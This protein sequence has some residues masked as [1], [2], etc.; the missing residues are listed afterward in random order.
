LKEIQNRLEAVSNARLEQ[1]GGSSSSSSILSDDDELAFWSSLFDSHFLSFKA[2]EDDDM[3]FF[4]RDLGMISSTSKSSTSTSSTS[5]ALV[6]ALDAAPEDKL[7]VLR[8]DSPY[9][10]ALTDRCIDWE[11]SVCLNAV[12]H[13][14][15]YKLAVAIG[16]RQA[17]PT[18]STLSSIASTSTQLNLFNK[19]TKRVYASPSKR[20]MDSK[21]GQTQVTYPILCFAVDDFQDIYSNLIVRP[22]QMLC[23]QVHPR[24]APYCQCKHKHTNTHTHT[25]TT[26]V[27]KY[28]LQNRIINSIAFTTGCCWY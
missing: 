14:F 23:V 9:I 6:S 17:Q 5:T 25:H 24:Q 4:V 27:F 11:H 10:P 3:L 20:R 13:R 28:T 8:R 15:T 12:L 26:C 16:E 19:V 2:E 1:H 18:T 22:G 21:E 7:L